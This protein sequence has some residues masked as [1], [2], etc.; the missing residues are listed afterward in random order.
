MLQYFAVCCSVL[1]CVAVFLSHYLSIFHHIEGRNITSV[2]ANRRDFAFRLSKERKKSQQNK[3]SAFYLS[4]LAQGRPHHTHTHTCTHICM[5]SHFRSHSCA[6]ARSLAL[7][8]L[9][10]LCIFLCC[11]AV[12][13]PS[14]TDTHTNTHKHTRGH[15]HKC[16]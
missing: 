12:V 16:T 4:P 7:L 2:A 11:F 1:Q 6:C 5:L 10:S 3:T 14:H 8:L 9:L 13:V 15:T